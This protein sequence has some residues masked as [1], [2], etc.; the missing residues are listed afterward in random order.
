MPVCF[1]PG[2][3][4]LLRARVPVP[5]FDLIEETAHQTGQSRSAVVRHLLVSALEARGQWP[6]SEEAG[7]GA[8]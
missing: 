6:P 1:E 2:R 3:S 8:Q 7:D 5:L 4:P